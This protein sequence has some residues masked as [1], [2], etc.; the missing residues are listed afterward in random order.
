MVEI[1][2]FSCDILLEELNFKLVVDV[3][4]NGGLVGENGMLGL[5]LDIIIVDGDWVFVVCVSEYKFEVVKL[6]VEVKE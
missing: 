6:L 4:F 2:W 3:I 5:N 1:G